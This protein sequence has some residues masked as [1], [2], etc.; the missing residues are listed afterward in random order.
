MLNKHSYTVNF[1]FR[2][3]LIHPALRVA[4]GGI[5]VINFY[6]N[7]NYPYEVKIFTNLVE[8]TGKNQIM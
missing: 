4:F 6:P 1:L 3:T 2:T 8:L 7:E 5:L